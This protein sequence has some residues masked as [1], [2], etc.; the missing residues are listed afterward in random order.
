VCSYMRNAV[1]E[2]YSDLEFLS[3][4]DKIARDY[5]KLLTYIFDDS[6]DM[7]N[8]NDLTACRILMVCYLSEEPMSANGMEQY[9]RLE[10]A[11]FSRALI[12]LIGLQ[13]VSTHDATLAGH[14]K[15][16]QLTDEGRIIAKKYQVVFEDVVGEP[17]DMSRLR[18]TDVERDR[19]LESLISLQNRTS[20]LL[21]K[22][23]H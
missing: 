9:L 7:S 12:K 21:R 1:L 6:I 8:V 5:K 4:A 20:A 13:Y 23:S 15:L 11:D 16:I 19:F 18:L 3:L 2:H 10:E 14:G 22:V 17:D